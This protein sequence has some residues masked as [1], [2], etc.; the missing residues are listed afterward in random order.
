MGVRVRVRVRH[1][2]RE[3]ATPALVNTGFEGPE[4]EIHLPLPLA[5][6]L[7]LSLEGARSERYAV[8][9]GEATA[10]RLGRVLVI[11]DVE[12]AMASEAEAVCV[13]GEYE[14]IVNDA[15]AEALG[16]EIVAPRRG[17][18]R[19]RGEAGLRESAAPALWV[20]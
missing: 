7:G 14:V 13:P 17:P 4:P 16:I 6:R 11:L 5:R 12:A 2:N 20:E 1:G 3:V 19:V 18:W 8:V 10:L 15:L 9:G